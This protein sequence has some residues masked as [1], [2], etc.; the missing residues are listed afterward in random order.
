MDRLIFRCG[1][2]GFAVLCAVIFSTGVVNKEKID[3]E[4][5]GHLVEKKTIIDPFTSS[6]G[7]TGG[8]T[9]TSVLAKLVEAPRKTERANSALQQVV[10]N[11]WPQIN[12]PEESNESPEVL[13]ILM[14]NTSTTKV[15]SNPSPA[16]LQSATSQRKNDV[17][18][19]L[20][21]KEFIEKLYEKLEGETI[22]D[23]KQIKLMAAANTTGSE[24]GTLETKREIFT[25][26]QYASLLVVE[27]KLGNKMKPEEAVNLLKSVDIVPVEEWKIEREVTC[28]LIEEVQNL[29]IKSSRRGLLRLNPVEIPPIVVAISKEYNLCLPP[30]AVIGPTVIVPAPPIAT[31]IAGSGKIS[32]S[33]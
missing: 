33:E 28:E 26:G 14:P 16:Q 31:G 9:R 12:Y 24:G 10:S 20:Q 27:L 30:E 7:S 29:T 19:L 11:E 17:S 13:N 2:V 6:P 21:G 1:L 22:S 4:N 3:D 23:G 18:L 25:Q 32:V 5:Q 8:N 15:R